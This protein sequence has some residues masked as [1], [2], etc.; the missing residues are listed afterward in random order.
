[1]AFQLRAFKRKRVKNTLGLLRTAYFV[2]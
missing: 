2:S 1:M